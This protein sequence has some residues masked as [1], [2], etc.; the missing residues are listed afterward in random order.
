MCWLNC[1]GLIKQADVPRF[2][3]DVPLCCINGD[4]C[5]ELQSGKSLSV[6]EDKPPS[7]D[8]TIEESLQNVKAIDQCFTSN[9]LITCE[10][11]RRSRKKVIASECCLYAYGGYPLGNSINLYKSTEMKTRETQI[12]SL[13]SDEPDALP[14]FSP[15]TLV[16]ISAAGAQFETSYL[17]Y[18]DFI[19]DRGQVNPDEHPLFPHYYPHSGG[20]KLG[21]NLVHALSTAQ[22]R[23]RQDLDHSKHSDRKDTNGLAFPSFPRDDYPICWKDRRGVALA[24][25]DTRAYLN[26]M[27]E[28]VWL[29]LKAFNDMV[30]VVQKNDIDSLQIEKAEYASTQETDEPGSSHKKGF[31][32]ATALGMGFFA[33]ILMSSSIQELLV[34]LLLQVCVKLIFSSLKVKSYAI[35]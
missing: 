33:R 31:F 32:K 35:K 3:T 10:D 1:L 12:E 17:E 18:H 27:R 28:D 14:S 2:L 34:P 13:L 11:R 26:S 4:R 9:G 8:T 25:F 15:N 21:W 22:S 5:V 6:P 29:I 19:I 16:I 23:E 7:M 24:Y 20:K 30:D